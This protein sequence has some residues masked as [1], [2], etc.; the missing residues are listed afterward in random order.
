[1][2][3][4]PLTT[5]TQKPVLYDV[6]KFGGDV[7]Q[8][9]LSG[10]FGTIVQWD[11]DAKDDVFKANFV[12]IM[13]RAFEFL[14][15][16]GIGA[17]IYGDDGFNGKIS[18][19]KAKLREHYGMYEYL[20]RRN[21]LERAKIIYALGGDAVCRTIPVVQLN[22]EGFQEFLKLSEQ[23]FPQGHSIVQG[24]DPAGRKFVSMR[25]CDLTLTNLFIVTAHQRYRETHIDGGRWVLNFTQVVAGYADT[26]SVAKFIEDTLH[27]RGRFIVRGF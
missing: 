3:G 15:V 14:D 20:L 16:V 19:Y 25:L 26:D 7:P 2:M 8:L 24:E 17:C 12:F 10:L 6:T 21:G 22:P 9:K 4:V 23:N 27:V 18:E 1:M 11:A 13:K 5:L